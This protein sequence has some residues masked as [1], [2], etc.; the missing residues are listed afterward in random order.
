LQLGG[1]EVAIKNMRDGSVV[2]TLTYFTSRK[3]AMVCGQSGNGEFGVDL[4]IL[5][6][7]KL[8]RQFPSAF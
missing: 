3:H 2:A 8:T 1:T 5:R 7:L 6:A 4:F